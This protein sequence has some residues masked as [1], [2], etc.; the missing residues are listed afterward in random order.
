MIVVCILCGIVSVLMYQR[1][2]GKKV[3]KKS[4]LKAILFNLILSLGI[5]SY[6]IGYSLT[7]IEAALIKISPNAIYFALM[8]AGV[9]IVTVSILFYCDK[10]RQNGILKLDYHL[11]KVD[12]IVGVIVIM[13]AFAVRFIGIDW[14]NGE[15][16]HPDEGNVV[17]PPIY[18]AE[19]N[20]FMSEETFYPAQLSGKILSVIYKV[21]MVIGNVFGIEVTDLSCVYIARA[22]IGVLS[23]GVVV[24]V[25]LIGNYL[26]K[27]AGT[28]TAVMVAF[29]L[30]FVHAAH[31][32]TGDTVVA[33]LLCLSILCALHYLEDNNDFV[34]V[35][36]MTL[37]AV[38]ATLEK[39]HGMF[40][41]ALV[42]LA[43]CMKQLR[44]HSF[45]KIITQGCFAII[46]AVISVIAIVPNLCMKI[47]EVYH[48]LFYVVDGFEGEATFLQNAY[49][50]FC[51]F[52]SYA[53]V[54]CLIPLIM[55]VVY[56]IKRRAYEV[57][58]LGIG[59]IYIIAMCLQNRHVIR[60]G[61]PFY[62]VLWLFIG[63][64]IAYIIELIKRKEI[65][66]RIIFAIGFM[67]VL[68]NGI[69]GALFVDILF[70]ST[71]YDT[72]VPCREWCLERGIVQEECIYDNRTCW[73][74]GGM[75]S[76]YRWISGMLLEEAL[77]ISGDSLVVNHLG[78][79]YAVALL[80]SEDECK[81][82]RYGIEKVAF[83]EAGYNYVDSRFGNYGYV[84]KKMLEPYNIFFNI[85][86][87]IDILKGNM[88]IGSNLA[89]YDIS[90]LDS[91]EKFMFSSFDDE[92]TEQGI[93][94]KNIINSIFA[95]SYTVEVSGCEN[96]EA[97][98]WI[99]TETGEC[100]AECDLV[101]GI[102]Q[103]MLEQDYTRLKLKLML[104][105]EF[106]NVKITMQ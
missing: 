34:W 21:W 31:C 4:F 79:N 86:T 41:F 23:V 95:G 105:G 48:S 69:T 37:L 39:Y 76:K 61:Y 56:F 10:L 82:E 42:A 60:W 12:K 99:M 2:R 102:G 16:F 71:K 92:E 32:V 35:F 74:P 47:G 18:M 96:K 59:F 97:R 66:Y 50:Y 52:L 68:L 1:W 30:P 29:F 81:I 70:G 44:K 78:K 36:F 83:F 77:E 53:G 14:G 22:Y 64:G 63:V 19:N 26:K 9:G 58:I 103:F 57:G 75:I 46:V 3:E 101:N 94:Y 62:L 55:G 90:M 13:S 73:Q 98:L 84:S 49:A 8:S 40:L 89:I 33:F 67:I 87:G 88:Y 24:C 17:R 65:Y 15:T 28:F 93:I 27:H 5:Y 100:L 104:D 106:D 80:K 11:T 25:F 54:I 45:M 72:R 85:C 51:W 7:E 43:V 91:Y 38:L 20:T 6:Y